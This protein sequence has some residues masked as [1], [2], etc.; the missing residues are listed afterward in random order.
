[1]C[2]GCLGQLCNPHALQAKAVPIH[3]LSSEQAAEGERQ[4]LQHGHYR[5]QCKIDS[6]T[7]QR[8]L[9][10]LETRIARIRAFHDEEFNPE[11]MELPANVVQDLL[12]QKFTSSQNRLGVPVYKGAALHEVG[13]PYP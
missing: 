3:H 12:V 9:E 1:M 2:I 7:A 6:S 5:S 10:A 8:T 11:C 13:E 4:A